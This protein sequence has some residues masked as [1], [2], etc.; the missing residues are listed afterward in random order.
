MIKHNHLFLLLIASAMFM[1]ACT[2][3]RQT[4]PS[5][6]IDNQQSSGD[7]H[8][9]LE[10]LKNQLQDQKDLYSNLLS[11]FN[12]L[13]DMKAEE[14]QALL[15]KIEAAQ[16]AAKT[17]AELVKEAQEALKNNE[18]IQENLVKMRTAMKAK[19]EKIAELQKTIE[20]SSSLSD[21]D[22]KPLLK[23][24]DKMKAVND[25]SQETLAKLEQPAST[26]ESP[27]TPDKTTP[28]EPDPN[29]ADP[30]DAAA[31]DPDAAASRAS[32]ATTPLEIT[33]WLQEQKVQNIRGT[34]VKF[35]SNKE[36]TTTHIAYGEFEFEAGD[37]SS[38]F[39]MTLPVYLKFKHDDTDK[40][41]TATLT[42][43]HWPT[44]QDQG[45]K[46]E[47]VAATNNNN[48]EHQNEG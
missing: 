18:A 2:S 38:E 26:P 22:K 20:N 47:M 43:A 12:S 28:T 4:S 44:T 7:S 46:V 34:Y 1:F 11:K 15:D 14:R 5:T 13:S 27:T 37:D 31:S 21:E 48:C 24:A 45:E 42:R 29:A 40:C 41:F 36:I 39:K 19:Q 35:G 6:P 17:S 9:A 8:Q 30:A 33:V 25:K 3:K 10:D 16:Q 23:E 32:D